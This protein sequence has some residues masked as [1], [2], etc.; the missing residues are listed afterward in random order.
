M[1]MTTETVRRILVRVACLLFLDAVRC[2]G[3]GGGGERRPPPVIALLLFLTLQAMTLRS[4]L[5]SALIYSFDAVYLGGGVNIARNMERGR[6]MFVSKVGRYTTVVS[7]AVAFGSCVVALLGGW[8]AE[9]E[10]EDEE[11]MEGGGGRWDVRACEVSAR[12][13]SRLGVFVVSF[14]L[15]CR[16]SSAAP[17]SRGS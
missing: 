7:A 5:R 13:S 8:F 4:I 10:E 2:G 6:K 15:L 3:G 11:G 17:P 12:A 14:L 16:S 9:E 1:G